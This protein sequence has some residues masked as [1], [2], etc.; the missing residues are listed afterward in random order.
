M[1]GFS[2]DFNFQAVWFAI[3][4]LYRKHIARAQFGPKEKGGLKSEVQ[5]LQPV[6]YADANEHQNLQATSGWNRIGG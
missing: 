1:F 6:R 5:H 4:D 2:A 3:Q